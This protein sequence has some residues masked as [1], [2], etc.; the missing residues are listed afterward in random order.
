MHVKLEEKKIAIER[1]TKTEGKTVG[2]G[3]VSVG[4]E[5]ET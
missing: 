5:N 2:H 1:Q 3:K 4:T